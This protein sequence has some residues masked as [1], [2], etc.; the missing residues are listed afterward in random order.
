M[1]ISVKRTNLTGKVIPTVNMKDSGIK[2]NHTSGECTF[3]TYSF[4]VP[5][6]P[7]INLPYENLMFIDIH[8]NKY[9][10]ADLV[11]WEKLDFGAFALK[12]PTTGLYEFKP[13]SDFMVD[14]SPIGLVQ[15][16]LYYFGTDSFYYHSIKKDPFEPYT[17]DILDNVTDGFYPFDPAIEVNQRIAPLP[18]VVS[19]LEP[20]GDTSVSTLSTITATDPKDF[21]YLPKLNVP[22]FL[23]PASGTYN[24]NLIMRSILYARPFSARP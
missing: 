1:A 8:G 18:A 12:N 10:T 3:Y 20:D 23:R 19:G 22:Y 24:K 16:G 2:A 6:T 14:K 15:L 9:N 13:I 17:Y 4:D 7:A 21:Y 5:F 11:I